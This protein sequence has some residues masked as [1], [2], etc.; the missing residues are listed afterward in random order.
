MTIREF[1]KQHPTIDY[2][3]DYYF[4][5]WCPICKKTWL[6]YD[7]EYSTQITNGVPFKPGYDFVV[8]DFYI[9]TGQ[10]MHN[11]TVTLE[12]NLIKIIVTAIEDEICEDCEEH[13][14]DDDE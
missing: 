11:A 7:E 3:I 14:H 13:Y 10:T 2:D 9:G 5:N 8:D 12:G 4:E 6:W 1:S